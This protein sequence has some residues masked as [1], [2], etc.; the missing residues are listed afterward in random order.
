MGG[1]EWEVQDRVRRNG[2]GLGWFG[3]AG[4][5]I[6]GLGGTRGWGEVGWC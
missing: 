2:V 5:V 3:L 6:V 1:A 4:V